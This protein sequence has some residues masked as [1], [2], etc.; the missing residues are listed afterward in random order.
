MLDYFSR[1]SSLLSDIE[2]FVIQRLYMAFLGPTPVMCS[3]CGLVLAHLSSPQSGS[4]VSL[5]FLLG[6]E[7]DNPI[8]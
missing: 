4:P 8:F 6:V 2:G 3:S 5:T 7:N 1:M